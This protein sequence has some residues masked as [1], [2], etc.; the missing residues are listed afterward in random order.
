MDEETVIIRN[1]NLMFW[2]QI[3][4]TP[5]ILLLQGYP[6][7]LEAPYWWWFS[8]SNRLVLWMKK[9]AF[10]CFRWTIVNILL[11]YFIIIFPPWSMLKWLLT[12]YFTAKILIMHLFYCVTTVTTSNK[13]D[14]NAFKKV[15]LNFLF[16]G[17]AN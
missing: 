1:L 3:D 12:W 14:T 11:D 10:A 17:I 13:T 15:F 4:F 2:S 5:E 16:W 6:E 9:V 8:D 7:R